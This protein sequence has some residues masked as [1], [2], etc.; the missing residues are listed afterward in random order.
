MDGGPKRDVCKGGPGTPDSAVNCEKTTGV[1]QGPR[2]LSEPLPVLRGRLP[3]VLENGL[4]SG[5]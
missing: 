1:P 5:N 4:Q 2:S 3:R